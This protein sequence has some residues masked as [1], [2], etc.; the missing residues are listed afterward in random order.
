[1]QE[2][3]LK[4]QRIVVT[5][6]GIVSPVGLTKKAFWDSLT[7]GRS[8]IRE[9]ESFNA[10]TYPTRVAGE[11]RNFDPI[12]FMS[13][14][15]ARRMDRS[16]QMIIAA[17][18]MALDD[19][20]IDFTHE[21]R[22]KVGVFTGT[23]VGGQAWAFREYAVFQEKGMSRINPFTAIATFPN[24]SSAQISGRFG[25]FGPSVTISSGC[26][27]SSL[28][29]GYAVDNIRLGRVDIAIVGGTE[30]PLDPGIFGAYCAARVMTRQNEKPTLVPKPF[31]LYRDGIVLS[32][33]AG[34]LICESAEHA[35]QRGGRIYAEVAGWAHN[36]DSTSMTMISPDGIQGRRVLYEAASASGLQT[37]DIELVMAHAA[38]T[39]A[40]D[41]IEAEILRSVFGARI[42]H[43]PVT[44]IKSMIGHTQGACGAIESAAAVLSIYTG[45]ALPT[46][47]SSSQDPE[48]AIR[49]NREKTV[50][51]NIHGLLL[52]TFGFG[53]KN[54]SVIFRAWDTEN[55]HFTSGRLAT[56]YYR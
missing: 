42:D 7:E 22:D 48:C 4:K 47:N 34:V 33:G 37:S 51:N 35:M 26:V 6:L 17:A 45:T 10:A 8:G 29:L 16:C 18:Q 43:L 5:G 27:S 41:K 21:Q 52:N 55:T 54:V 39:K 1:M 50:Q 24:A 19:S 9:L 49:V 20:R 28:A 12:V 44:A 3:P 14:K 38:G 25:F 23:A 31:D 2:N 30:A 32:E 11:V 15:E 56:E 36:S 13:H 46:I 53:G 40:D